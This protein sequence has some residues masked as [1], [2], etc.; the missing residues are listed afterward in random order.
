MPST[1]PGTVHAPPESACSVTIA[2][3]VGCD[4]NSKSAVVIAVDDAGTPLDR[5]P[6]R[7]TPR[8]DADR[9]TML[10]DYLERVV[11][12]LRDISAERVVFTDVD[13]SRARPSDVRTQGH[14]EATF[15][16]AARQARAEAVGVHQR[17]IASHLGLPPSARKREIREVVADVVGAEV[18][19]PDPDRRARALGGVWAA[20]N[21]DL[22]G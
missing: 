13:L 15:M 19:S 1:R 16:L 22:G 17:A 14:L 12:H 3:L 6:D 18:L 5:L 11:Q 20:Q 8:H 10:S 4:I 21:L 2:M 9:A 7:L